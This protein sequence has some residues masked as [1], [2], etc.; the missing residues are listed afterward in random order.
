M[1]Q[2]VR[3]LLLLLLA[4]VPKCSTTAPLGALTGVTAET[5]GCEEPPPLP[6]SKLELLQ[7]D[8]KRASSYLPPRPNIVLLIS[9]DVDREWLGAYRK[10]GQ[11]VTPHLD[12]LARNGARFSNA[13]SS[14][15][16]CAPSRYGLLTGRW[17]SRSPSTATFVKDL[18]PNVKLPDDCE[19]HHSVNG[20]TLDP[21]ETNLA[22]ELKALGY[23]TGF[24]GKWHVS[25]EI[26]MMHSPLKDRKDLYA[27]MQLQVRSRGF[28][29]AHG[30]YFTNVP[31]LRSKLGPEV[32]HHQEWLTDLAADFVKRGGRE[33]EE[34]ASQEPLAEQQPRRPFFLVMASTLPHG[35]DLPLWPKDNE[36]LR[37]VE[38]TEV[39]HAKFVDLKRKRAAAHAR[40]QNVELKNGFDK[41]VKHRHQSIRWLVQYIPLKGNDCAKMVLF[42][43]AVGGVMAALKESGQWKDTLVVYTTDHGWTDKGFAYEGS[44]HVPLLL[45]WPRLFGGGSG[46]GSGESGLVLPQLVSTIDIA[47]TAV[48]AGS[49]GLLASSRY[50]Q[51]DYSKLVAMSASTADADSSS[52]SSSRCGSTI[53]STSDNPG[54]SFVVCL[55]TSTLVTH[56]RQRRSFLIRARRRRRRAAGRPCRFLFPLLFLRVLFRVLALVVNVVHDVAAA[57][58]T[59][60]SYLTTIADCCGMAYLCGVIAAGVCILGQHR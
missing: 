1:A 60:R 21:R 34:E 46:S 31:Q 37:T 5:C 26:A 53:G 18:V 40:C 3:L 14:A 36:T 27:W 30:L 20:T 51:R 29:E 47:A 7:A 52:S 19:A 58:S 38:G 2:V 45:Q 13:Y 41:M 12:R 50:H 25:S 42:D 56:H 39:S 28:D 22:L 17:P 24:V 44:S 43:D 57:T 55:N 54:T 23:R 4:W 48:E 9:D 10:D 16:T 15:S 33:A 59:V 8:K 11:S 35:P 49:R 32:Q 6:D